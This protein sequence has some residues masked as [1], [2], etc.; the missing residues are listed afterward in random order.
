MKVTTAEFLCSIDQQRE[1]PSIKKPEIAFAGRSNVG[2][3]S[4]INTLLGRKNLV[5]T[6]KTPGLTRKINFFVVN[7]L[8]VFVD[9]PGYGFAAVP[10]EIRKQW[11]P[12]VETYLKGREELAGVVVIVD[13]RRE[14][15][16]FDKTLFDFL[17]SNGILFVVALSKIDKITNSLFVSQIRGL[18]SILSPEIPAVGFSA[19]TGTGKNELWKAIKYLIECQKATRGSLRQQPENP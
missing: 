13:S 6:S 8:L 16:D 11:G 2:K 17:Q 12:M 15:T 1:Y 14:P 3:S 5:R 9:L 7:N 19:T 10:L 18:R 4:M